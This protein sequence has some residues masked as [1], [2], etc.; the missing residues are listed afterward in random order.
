M[1]T[2]ALTD[3]ARLAPE[4]ER[5]VV[6]VPQRALG[7][8]TVPAVGYGAMV[9]SPGM[10][11]EI[12]DDHALRA[13]HHAVDSGS[14]FIDT[15]DAYGGGHN[16]SLIA[17]LLKDRRDEV[18]I[19]TK[20]G[21][22]LDDSIEPHRFPVGFKFGELAVNASPELVRPFAEASLRRLGI[23]VIDLYYPHFPD[24]IVPIEDTVG[25]M[26][27]LVDAGLIRGIG[28]SNITVDQL[29]AALT[30]YPIDAIQVEWSMWTPIDR[31]LLDLCRREAVGIVAWSPLGSGFLSGAVTEVASGDFREHAPRFDAPNLTVNRARFA[32]LWD[33]AVELDLRPTE[34]ALAWLLHQYE[35]VVAI[36]GSRTPAH[37]GSNAQS[38]TVRLHADTLAAIGRLLDNIDVEGSGLLS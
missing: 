27:E 22:L 18:T 12:N 17:R 5:S 30:V 26:A 23:D 13:L 2:N 11:G 34:L 24:P 32:S 29:R 33:T 16:E 6:P 35:H 1:T 37:I 21:L 20:F 14:S 19:A 15:S 3:S 28:L 31:D 9:L 7:A 10:Y 38:A 4:T 8:L 36:P 25:A